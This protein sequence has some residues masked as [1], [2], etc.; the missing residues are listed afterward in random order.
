MRAAHLS[1][2]L[3]LRHVEPLAASLPRCGSDACTG[4]QCSRGVPVP[5]LV[6]KRRFERGF[7]EAS[8]CVPTATEAMRDF[9]ST[10]C[11]RSRMGPLHH[12]T[13]LSFIPGRGRQTAL[14]APS[15]SGL[16]QTSASRREAASP[17]PAHHPRSSPRPR[18]PALAVGTRSASA[19]TPTASRPK[20]SHP[21]AAPAVQLRSGRPDGHSLRTCRHPRRY[22]MKPLWKAAQR[23]QGRNT[24]RVAHRARNRTKTMPGPAHAALGQLCARPARKVVSDAPGGFRYVMYLL[25]RCVTMVV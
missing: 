22:V 4:G 20:E 2:D 21:Q 5:P 9:L 23:A 24:A 8:G 25:S 7:C 13:P 6:F 3:E 18:P 10:R 12:P 11:F 15:L 17:P 14:H 1:S 16:P 19:Q